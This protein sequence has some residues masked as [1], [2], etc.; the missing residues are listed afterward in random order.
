VPEYRPLDDELKSEIRDE[1]LRTRTRELMKQAIRSAADAVF[2]QRSRYLAESDSGEGTVSH[3]EIESRMRKYADEH[4][5]KFEE[6]KYLSEAELREEGAGSIGTATDPSDG[7]APNA[8]VRPVWQRLRQ[9]APIQLFDPMVVENGLTSDLY[10]VWKTGDR[11]EHVPTL[12][13]PGVQEE[14]VQAWKLE[15]ARPLADERAQ[16]LADLVRDS[17]KG[18]AEALK[19]QTITGKEGSPQLTSRL[20][21]SFS[22]LRE[23]SAP[24][25]DM[26]RPSP[27]QL[28]QVA[29]I[30][31]I[32][33][34]FMRTIFKEM[35]NGEIRSIPN[36]DKSVYYVVEVTDR[37]PSTPEDENL[38]RQMFLRENLFMGPFGESPYRYQMRLQDSRIHLAWVTE[39]QKK[40]GVRWTEDGRPTLSM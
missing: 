35:S 2:A 18:M 17:K 28:T 11:V 36:R 31:N 6:T 8:N 34:E 20:T 5:L 7:A 33:P 29:A 25:P 10:A 9:S 3:E 39:L 13:E 12:D 26:F 21:E 37:F 24:Q 40:Y 1:L 32:S 22:W 23:S 30:K 27:P 38:F 14:V 15:K 19:D 16:K 4:G